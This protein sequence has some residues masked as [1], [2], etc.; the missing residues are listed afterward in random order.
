MSVY[1]VDEVLCLVFGN[2]IGITSIILIT[3]KLRIIQVPSSITNK[4]ILG[5]SFL[6]GIGFTMA[7]FIASL[8]FHDQPSYITSAKIGIL[9]GSLISAVIGYIILR[10]QP[11]N[12]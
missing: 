5:V 4:H 6:A 9:I 11:K 2:S 8:A 3:K 10:W 12:A 1:I 7:I